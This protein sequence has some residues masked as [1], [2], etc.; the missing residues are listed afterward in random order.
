MPYRPLSL[1][2]IGFIFQG[3]IELKGVDKLA[4]PQRLTKFRAGIQEEH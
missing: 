3:E 2:K 1:A 4:Q